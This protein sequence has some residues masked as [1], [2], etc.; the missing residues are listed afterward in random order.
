[1]NMNGELK[2]PNYPNEE[3]KKCQHIHDNA[4]GTASEIHWWEDRET[5]EKHGFKFKDK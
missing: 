3:W 1:M 5:G 4:D 2:D